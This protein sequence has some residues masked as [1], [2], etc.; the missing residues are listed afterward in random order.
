MKYIRKGPRPRKYATWRASVAGSPN[1]RYSEIPGDEKRELLAALIEE[2]GFLCAYTMKRIDE[3]N[4]HIEHIKPQV[5][6]RADR[7]GSDLD[8]NNMVACFPREGMK[9]L[10]RY[11]AQAKGSWWENDGSDFVS[12]L[13][14]ACERRLRFGLDGKIAAVGRD[15]GAVT[16]NRILGLNHPSLVEDRRGAIEEFLYGPSRD[17]PISPAKA[18]RAI[19]TICD[20]KPDRHFHEFCVAIRGGLQEHIRVIEKRARRRRFARGGR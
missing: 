5:K 7:R 9:A 11:G 1:E 2:Q 8:Y 6:C 13:Q 4:S 16:T 12:P 10:Y 20:R 17:D 15:D 18:A 19:A 3:D 14:Q